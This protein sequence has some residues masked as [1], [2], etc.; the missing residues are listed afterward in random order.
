MGAK[1][2]ISVAAAHKFLDLLEA[3][4]DFTFQ[5]F[6]D[7]KHRKDIRLARVLHGNLAQHAEAL[8]SLQA[9]GAGVFV[10]VNRGDG[11]VHPGAKTCRAAASV[12]AVR[13]LF[14]DLDGAPLEPV[15][16]ALTPD[17]IV[18]SSPGRWH[19]YWKTDDC[20]L[21]DFT[22]RQKQI[23]AK[24]RGDPKV[25]DLPRVMRLPGFLHQKDKPFLTRLV[26]PV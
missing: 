5:T 3:G 24:F 17:I 15:K 13:A 10:M 7:N 6:D 19:T 11:V 9:R 1:L 20:P 4:G 26:H 8:I 22:L 2:E 23:A 14:A 12:V 16:A 21:H 18:E 25:V